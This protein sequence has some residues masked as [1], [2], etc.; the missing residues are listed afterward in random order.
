MVIIMVRRKETEIL[1]FE[2]LQGASAPESVTV[3]NIDE[4][5][6]KLEKSER[7]VAAGK[8]IP[9]EVLFE[10]V[11]KRYGYRGVKMRNFF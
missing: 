6:A 7:N 3:R 11:R 2:G 8:T 1:D 9:A 10:K 4:L 5:Y